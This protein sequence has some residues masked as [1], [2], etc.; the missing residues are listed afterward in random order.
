[1][2]A[3]GAVENENHELRNVTPLDLQSAYH[4]R[5]HYL[6]AEKSERLL[7][8]AYQTLSR[9]SQSGCN[10]IDAQIR[11]LFLT[12]GKSEPPTLILRK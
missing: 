3:I 8:W 10:G 7:C 9:K 5:H 2:F 6:Q 4:E 11:G 12:G 1:M